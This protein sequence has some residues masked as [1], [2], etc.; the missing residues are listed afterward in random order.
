MGYSPRF[1]D[2]KRREAWA[3][4]VHHREQ[5]VAK[6]MTVFGLQERPL[7][8]DI[9]DDVIEVVQGARLI[10]GVLPLDTYGQS[11][12]VNGSPEIT[13][14]S[15]IAKMP[16]VKDASGVGYITRWHESVHVAYDLAV[17]SPTRQLTFPGLENSAPN[18]I[19]CRPNAIG[20]P[21]YSRQEFIAENAGVAAA[22]SHSDLEKCEAFQ[23][24]LRS[25]AEGGDLGGSGFN[26]LYQAAEYVGA[27]PSALINYLEKKGYYSLVRKEGKTRMFGNPQLDI[28]LD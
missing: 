13:I 28:R 20:G 15:R 11:E 8:K 23:K 5:L 24:F 4:G 12:M 6:Y 16:G 27:N 19:V 9:V 1:I 14:N 22:I 10:E 17:D 26:L 2:R 21:P 25:V 3:L 18:L 7:L